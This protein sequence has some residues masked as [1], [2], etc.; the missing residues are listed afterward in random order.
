MDAIKGLKY[1]LVLVLVVSSAL[2]A[3][4]TY[5]ERS[6]NRKVEAFAEAMAQVQTESQ[7]RQVIRSFMINSKITPKGLSAS[8][9][10]NTCKWLCE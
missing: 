2:L 3:W 5:L 6:Q 8:A 7:A 10:D 9:D 1:A 4:T